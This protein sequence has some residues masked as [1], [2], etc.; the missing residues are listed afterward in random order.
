MSDL[1]TLD[2]VDADGAIREAE[3]QVAGDTRADFFRKAAVGGGVL[4]GGSVLMSGFPALAAAAKPSKA[5]DVKILNYALTLEYLENA[6]YVEALAKAGL[7]GDALRAAQVIQAHEQAHVEFLRKALG[8]AAVKKP[9][10]AF[11][12]ATANQA[13]FLAT[14][15]VLEDTGVAAYAGQGPRLSQK[16]VVKAALSIHSVEARHAAFVRELAGMSFAPKAFDKPLAMGP[17]LK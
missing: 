3:D 17:V 15:V 1:I 11:G 13:N 16:P 7:S 12:D 8:K 4:L 14:A 5:Q 6:F 2:L 10:F 9:R